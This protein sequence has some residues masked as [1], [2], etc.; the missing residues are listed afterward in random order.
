MTYTQKWQCL[1]LYIVSDACFC[2]HMYF[3]SE[4]F[5]LD[6]DWTVL[7]KNTLLDVRQIQKLCF[8]VLC[9]NGKVN[10]WDQFNSQ[11]HNKRKCEK[12]TSC[13]KLNQSIYLN[14]VY[15]GEMLLRENMPYIQ[16]PAHL[17]CLILKIGFVIIF[18]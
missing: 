6:Q 11:L 12:H 14:T 9:Y 7:M 5:F 2:V 4:E 13:P 16:A 18:T 8:I 3:I 1:T 10:Q 17:T 15:D